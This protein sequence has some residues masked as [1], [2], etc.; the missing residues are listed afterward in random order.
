MIYENECFCM[1]PIDEYKAVLQCG[2]VFHSTCIVLTAVHDGGLECPICRTVI[3]PRTHRNN[4]MNAELNPE[5]MRLR[6]RELELLREIQNHEDARLERQRQIENEI[7]R[8]EEARLERQRIREE[9]RLE[10]IRETERRKEIAID[11]YNDDY[12]KVYQFIQLHRDLQNVSP[13]IVMAA[14]LKYFDGWRERIP[15]LNG[16]QDIPKNIYK[17]I[18]CV[19]LDCTVY[20]EYKQYYKEYILNNMNGYIKLTDELQYLIPELKSTLIDLIP[21]NILLVLNEE[22]NEYLSDFKSRNFLYYRTDKFFTK[23]ANETEKNENYIIE[24]NLIES[25]HYPID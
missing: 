11:R 25:I 1:E 17:I 3:L 8:Q 22:K 7:R 14:K 24:Y 9:E 19:F 4:Q 10:R 13:S 23:Y 18:A 5:L 15:K 2:H 16:A 6:R 21:E 20:N 12:D